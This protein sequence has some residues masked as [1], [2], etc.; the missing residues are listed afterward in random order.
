MQGHLWWVKHRWGSEA[1]SLSGR[2]FVICILLLCYV[3]IYLLK[4]VDTLNTK[5]KFLTVV[6]SLFDG[7]SS[8]S[9]VK[10]KNHNCGIVDWYA[11]CCS[12]IKSLFNK[13]LTC[14]SLLLFLNLT[15]FP[16]SL[17]FLPNKYNFQI[18]HACCITISNTNQQ[19]T[20]H[21]VKIHT[22]TYYIQYIFN[23]FQRQ[24]FKSTTWLH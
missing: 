21:S 7:E 12:R 2:K 18:I 17:F 20:I 4:E 6:V 24:F 11:C 15:S 19:I 10:L 13:K 8:S 14:L 1:F 3:G 16:C 22:L 23:G 9:S 5:F